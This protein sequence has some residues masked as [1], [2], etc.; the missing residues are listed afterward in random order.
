MQLSILLCGAS[1]QNFIVSIL[2][3][4]YLCSLSS[5]NSHIYVK[6]ILI[7]ECIPFDDS[8][9]R[10]SVTVSHISFTEPAELKKL[11]LT[12]CIVSRCSFK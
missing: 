7:R 1:L 4:T 12:G 9:Q 8:V 3:G 2:S 11:V 10:H 5:Y 6:C